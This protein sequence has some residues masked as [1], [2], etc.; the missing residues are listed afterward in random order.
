MTRASL[1]A[2]V[3]LVVACKGDKKDDT[4]A[5]QMPV[6]PPKATADA[7][8]IGSELKFVGCAPAQAA[9]GIA[10]Y[11]LIGRGGRAARLVPFVLWLLLPLVW[12]AMRSR[13]GQS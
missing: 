12:V 7:A 10:G 11:G 6:S 8:L 13:W 2:L 9:P 4:P 5:R 3:T 1:V